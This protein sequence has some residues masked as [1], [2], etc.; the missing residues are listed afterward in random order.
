[1]K[2]GVPFKYIDIIKNMI[3]LKI[4][5]KE[6][7]HQVYLHNNGYVQWSSDEF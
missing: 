2:K 7:P 3:M 1:M 5:E 4:D 6:S